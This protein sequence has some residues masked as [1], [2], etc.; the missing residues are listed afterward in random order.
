[1]PFAFRPLDEESA[2][3]ILYWKYEAPYDIYNLA[4]PEPEETLRYLL[5][6]QYAFYGIYEPQGD[7]EAFCSFGPD[8]R[9]S[10]GE[11]STPALDI[12]LGLR[13]DLTGHGHGSRYVN[14]VIEFASSTYK[15]DRLR[16]T[17][18]AF[19]H[20]ALRLWEKAG[21]QVEQKFK[22]GWDNRDFVV[23]TKDLP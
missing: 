4:R 22:G 3:T 16:V 8:G 18:A 17:I 14:A 10:G 11:Y 9:V 5:D 7:L 12:G 15:P 13:P 19:N 6:P 2:R 21:F 20:R 23:L 1:M